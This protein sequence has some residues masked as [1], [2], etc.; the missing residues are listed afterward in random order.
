MRE[1]VEGSASEGTAIV[2][3]ERA[4]ECFFDEK[5]KEHFSTRE[6]RIYTDIHTIN[7]NTFF[8]LL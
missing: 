3:W 8:L 5:Q 7:R 6:I 1:R 2:N 4:C